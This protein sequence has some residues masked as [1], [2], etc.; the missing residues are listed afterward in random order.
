MTNQPIVIDDSYTGQVSP[1]SAPQRRTV[2][3]AVITKMSVGP[4]DNNTY[5]VVCST[6]GK[7][8]LI[9]AANE[10]E[11]IIA[12]IEQEAPVFDSIVTTHQ[13]GDHW[14][15]LQDVHAATKVPT[16]AH[17]LDA[18]VLPVTPD[19]L[20]EDGHKVTVGN[21]SL[22][23]IHLSGHTPGSIALALIEPGGQVHLFTGDSLFPGGVGK[24][25]DPEKFTS[26]LD[27]VENKLFGRYDDATVVY[28]GHGKDTTLGAER[29]H[30]AEWRE[31]GW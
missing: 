16:A 19:I 21:L 8:L 15:A 27:D 3:G 11:K 6:T 14:L 1:N 28:P 4:M 7:S 30:L 25:A 22:D 5:L 17:P 18:E 12:L 24:T 9:D 2:D 10:A 23:V 13:H 29:P 31:R 20:L 26:L